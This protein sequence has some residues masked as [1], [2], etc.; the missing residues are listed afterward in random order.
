MRPTIS[1]TREALGRL[2]RYLISALAMV[3]IEGIVGQLFIAILIARLVG[4]YPQPGAH[5]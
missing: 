4:V 5:R 3:M 2:F 1:A